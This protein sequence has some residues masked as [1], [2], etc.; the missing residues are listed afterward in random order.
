MITVVVTVTDLGLLS[1]SETM[2]RMDVSQCH[3]GI[4]LHRATPIYMGMGGNGHSVP[5]AWQVSG[6]MQPVSVIPPGQIMSPGAHIVGQ[7]P[8]HST[9]LE[10][11]PIILKEIIPYLFMILL[12]AVDN[13]VDRYMS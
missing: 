3:R 8:E 11:M 10:S 13:N 9:P 7:T 5:S 2:T 4:S 6:S 12:K 1:K